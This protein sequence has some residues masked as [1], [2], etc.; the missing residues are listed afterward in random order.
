MSNSGSTCTDICVQFDRG[1][2][3]FYSEAWTDFQFSI[4]VLNGVCSYLNRHWVTR[5]RDE[6]GDDSQEKVYA[7]L[8]LGVIQWKEIFYGKLCKQ[9][10]NEILKGLSKHSHER[11]KGY[12]LTWA[13]DALN[14]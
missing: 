10:V 1:L 11:P 8:D 14:F 3:L 12:F 5:E 4:K 6:R 2:L 13:A 7:I 9:L